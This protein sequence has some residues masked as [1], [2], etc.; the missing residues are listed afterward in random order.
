MMS[1]F[2]QAEGNKATKKGGGD[3]FDENAM[4]LNIGV[5]IP[6]LGYTYGSG[7]YGSFAT[8]SFSASLEAGVHK[9]ISVGGFV[10]FDASGYY[11]DYGNWYYN[12]STNSYSSNKRTYSYTNFSFGAKGSFHFS[13]IGN[14]KWGWNINTSKVDL[15]A[16]AFL[17]AALGG[18]S[19]TDS[20]NN[21][22]TTNGLG[23]RPV[24]G[25]AVGARY[26]FSPTIG[27]FGEVGPSPLGWVVGGLTIKLK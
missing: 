9:W 16:S 25:A 17:G 5:G 2:A 6:W 18:S 21:N 23:V 22:T 14:E 19:Y 20:Y 26:L 1:S 13:A 12:S 3:V 8:P 27:V 11:V 7:Y 4:L 24:A 10:E 15:Y